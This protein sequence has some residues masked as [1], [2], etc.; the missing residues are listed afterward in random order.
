MRGSQRRSRPV[1]QL[2]GR[3]RQTGHRP[4]ARRGCPA[5][6]SLLPGR[7]SGPLLLPAPLRHGGAALGCGDRRWH[8]R[9]QQEGTGCSKHSAWGGGKPGKGHILVCTRS[10]TYLGSPVSVLGTVWW[11]PVPVAGR[12]ALPAVGSARRCF[13]AASRDL[14]W[15]GSSSASCVTPSFTSSRPRPG[16]QLGGIRF[17]SKNAGSA[18]RFD[19]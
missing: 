10:P 18:V 11:L 14:P 5:A 12:A 4:R 8:C 1:A 15:R 6:P 3:L 9:H 2:S 13:P 7:S 17:S 19:S 16:W